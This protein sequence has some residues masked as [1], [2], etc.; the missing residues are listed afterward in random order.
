MIDRGRWSSSLMFVLAATGSAIGLGNI[1]KFPYITGVYGGGAFVLVYLFCI[2][3]VGVPIF[4]AE[5]YVGQTAQ[6]SPILAFDHLHRKNS[7]WRFVGWLGVMSSFLVLCFY[8]VVGGWVFDFLFK[9]VTHAFVGKTDEEITGMFGVLISSPWMV[10]FWH[11]VF[12]IVTIVIVSVG[13]SK[14]IERVSRVLMPAL[15]LILVS[16]FIW[17]I[18]LDG[19]SEALAFLFAPDFSKLSSKAILVAVGHSFFTL[20]LGMGTMITYGS[21]LNKSNDILKTSVLVSLLDTVVALVAGI[22]VF[23]VVFTFGHEPAAGPGLMFQT[24]PSLFAKMPTGNMV[25]IAFFL[26]VAFAALT[27]AISLLEV[28]IAYMVDSGM[29]D[30]KAATYQ[31]GGMIFALGILA[32]LSFNV[33]ADFKIGRFTFFDLFDGVTT[34]IFLPL[35]GLLTSLFVAWMMGPKAIE[36]ILKGRG[37]P[38]AKDSLFWT[39]AIIAPVCVAWVL[40]QGISDWIQG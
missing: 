9:S 12:M 24:L 32:A 30:R 39:M 19:F 2:A 18:F 10:L 16:L 25:S 6:K 20:S 35:G 29:K 21:Y 14:G 37:G 7:P 23:S 5:L 38:L 31:I 40:F 22:V 17:C 11:A 26:L 1:W 8:S 3:L 4:M 15:L 33:L 13:L 34:N 28:V 27:S 36:F